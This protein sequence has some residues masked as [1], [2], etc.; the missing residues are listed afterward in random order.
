VLIL[1]GS[2]V[3]MRRYYGFFPLPRTLAPALLSAG[4]MGAVLWVLR[5]LPVVLLV[6]AGAALYGVLLWLMSP[7][8]R[9]LAAGVRR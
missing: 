3:L 8:S 5:E 6:P 9:E 4:V 7:A 2:Y 1:A